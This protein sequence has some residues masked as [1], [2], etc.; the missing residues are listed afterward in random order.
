MISK[1]D[2]T[3]F[4][5]STEYIRVKEYIGEETQATFLRVAGLDRQHL[6]RSFLGEMLRFLRLGRTK[7]VQTKC[8]SFETIERIEPEFGG[9]SLH[10]TR[11]TGYIAI[12]LTT[13]VSGH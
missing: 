7:I 13:G 12:T 10:R 4:I 1:T 2:S 11:S 3:L 5:Y 8:G 9:A 6:F